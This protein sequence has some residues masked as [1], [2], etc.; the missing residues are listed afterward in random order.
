MDVKV[1]ANDISIKFYQ[2]LHK[3]QQILLGFSRAHDAKFTDCFRSL[4]CN[5][6]KAPSFEKLHSTAVGEQLQFSVVICMSVL[7]VKVVHI[8]KH[9]N[10]NSSHLDL[11]FSESCLICLLILKRIT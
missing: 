9:C 10:L 6:N 1:N 2:N 5:L 7:I 4:I 11:F 8:L 3:T